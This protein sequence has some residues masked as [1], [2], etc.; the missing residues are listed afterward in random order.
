MNAGGHGTLPRLARTERVKRDKVASAAVPKLRG[1][2]KGVAVTTSVSANARPVGFVRQP[3]GRFKRDRLVPT[4]LGVPIAIMYIRAAQ[5]RRGR[6]GARCWA[7]LLRRPW[8]RESGRRT[9]S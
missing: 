3:S 4:A 8:P 2:I 1:F 9:K 6:G 7:C 5:P